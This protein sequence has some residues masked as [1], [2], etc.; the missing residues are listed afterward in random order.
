MET[1]FDSFEQGHLLNETWGE[2]W[3][4]ILANCRLRKTILE[5]STSP[6]SKAIPLH[7]WTGPEGSRRLRLP[8]FKTVGTWRW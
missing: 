4:K 8:Y 3:N 5:S 1:K 2:F 7:A 6:T